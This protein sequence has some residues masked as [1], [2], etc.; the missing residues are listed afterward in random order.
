[1]AHVFIAA[2]DHDVMGAGGD[3]CS[4]HLDG[5]LGRATGGPAP[6]RAPRGVPGLQP[7]VAADVAGLLADGAVQPMTRSSTAAGSIPVR[8]MSSV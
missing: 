7:G 4:G 3:E 5:G 1:M 6:W 8:V 2:G